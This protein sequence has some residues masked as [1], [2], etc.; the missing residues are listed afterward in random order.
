[1]VG[2]VRAPSECLGWPVGHGWSSCVWTAQRGMYPGEWF[3]GGGEPGRPAD[4]C[5]G[6]LVWR[7][8]LRAWELPEARWEGRC[9]QG[10]GS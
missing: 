3:P 10:G 5:L 1:M 8:P 2:P 4:H 6:R 9:E 7:R